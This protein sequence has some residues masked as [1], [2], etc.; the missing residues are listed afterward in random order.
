MQGA[1][2]GACATCARTWPGN[3][4]SRSWATCFL[5]VYY[6]PHATTV[7]T[8]SVKYQIFHPVVLF[9]SLRHSYNNSRRLRCLNLHECAP[10]GHADATEMRNNE[11][12]ATGLSQLS[13]FQHPFCSSSQ[14]SCIAT[15]RA[16]VVTSFRTNSFEKVCGEIY[17]FG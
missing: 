16:F 8:I 10:I 15:G 7:N 1:G 9:P 17:N 2:P 14:F 6:F 5:K 11:Y 3:Q 12:N 4:V 13:Q